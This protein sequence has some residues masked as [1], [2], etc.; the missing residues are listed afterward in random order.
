MPQVAA[1]IGGYLTQLQ[2]Y[3]DAFANMD[4]LMLLPRAE[5]EALHLKNRYAAADSNI[6]FTPTMIPEE[7]A[8]TWFRPFSTFESVPLKNGPTVSN[9]A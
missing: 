4:M 8:G 9:V 5:R 3:D 2:S 6:V 7:R 1:Q